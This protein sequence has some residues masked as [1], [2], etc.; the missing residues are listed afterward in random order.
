MFVFSGPCACLVG[1][2]AN[3]WSA[4]NRANHRNYRPADVQAIVRALSLA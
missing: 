2:G 4:L 3:G 1:A